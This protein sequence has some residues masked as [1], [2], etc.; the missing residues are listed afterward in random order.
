MVDKDKREFGAWWIWVVVLMVFAGVTFTVLGYMGK[1][2]GTFVER[3]VF[4]QSYQR[5]EGLK[6]QQNA[7]EAQ[8]ASINVHLSQV[9]VG[10]DLHNQLM[11]QKAMLEVQIR[12]TK[13]MK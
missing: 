13:G 9:D 12:Q 4:E 10:S 1:F 3:K 11:S 5:S 7:W 2:T 6:S 8:L